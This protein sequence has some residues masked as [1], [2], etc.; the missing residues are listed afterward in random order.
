MTPKGAELQ[1]RYTHFT[2]SS[3]PG[4]SF[5]SYFM[6]GYEQYAPLPIALHAHAAVVIHIKSPVPSDPRTLKRLC[7]P[8]LLVTDKTALSQFSNYPVPSINQTRTG[9]KGA[10]GGKK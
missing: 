2:F 7:T 3:I 10:K 9:K 6:R 1:W 4:I 8:P 5:R